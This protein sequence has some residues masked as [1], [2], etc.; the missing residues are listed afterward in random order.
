MVPP[1]APRLQICVAYYCAKYCRK[2]E[3]NGIFV[4]LNK[5]KH[6]TIKIWYNLLG[7]LLSIVN[8]RNVVMRHMTMFLNMT[9]DIESLTIFELQEIHDFYVLETHSRAKPLHFFLMV[10]FN[11]SMYFSVRI[12]QNHGK[13]NKSFPTIA[14]I[15]LMKI[16]FPKII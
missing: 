6:N 3:H 1:V 5:F 14:V 2:L 8:D 9:M 7:P 16:I 4:C 13:W 15:T 11:Y 10:W 12:S